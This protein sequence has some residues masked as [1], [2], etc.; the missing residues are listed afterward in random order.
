MSRMED[1]TTMIPG[2]TP[3]THATTPECLEKTL[4]T[5]A[6]TIQGVCID[7]IVNEL[8]WV[9]LECW[10]DELR[11]NEHLHPFT[12]LVPVLTE[13]CA[14]RQLSHHYLLDILWLCEQMSDPQY[15][16]QIQ[17]DLRLLEGILGGISADL[18]IND[19]ELSGLRGWL[20]DHVHLHNCWPYDRVDQ[21]IERA[22]LDGKL[23]ADEHNYLVDCFAQIAANSNSST[24]LISTSP[25]V[26]V[27][28]VCAV[29]PEIVIA[30]HRFCF[31]GHGEKQSHQTL[32]QAVKDRYGIVCHSV[33]EE[34][35]YLVVCANRNMGWKYHCFG[36]KVGDAIEMQKHSGKLQIVHESDLQAA[37][38]GD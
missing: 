2:R 35:D 23:D 33:S 30:Q 3:A 32:A 29:N 27:N 28:D 1:D 14:S 24:G 4:Y 8:E 11:G 17:H 7:G 38:D 19:L 5:L 37:I 15:T 36:R 21:I 34:L 22:M 10:L 31:T 26:L 12:E 6:G 13:A 20:H 16:T 25:L 18:R 9:H